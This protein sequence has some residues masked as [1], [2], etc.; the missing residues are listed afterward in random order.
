MWDMTVLQ[1]SGFTTWLLE[2]LELVTTDIKH[3]FS[4]T[5]LRQVPCIIKRRKSMEGKSSRLVF[6][7][8]L[9]SRQF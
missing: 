2:W 6:K 5:P 4:S 8:I 3:V 9:F 7:H 1:V